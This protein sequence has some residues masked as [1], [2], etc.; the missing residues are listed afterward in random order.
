MMDPTFRVRLPISVSLILIS[1]AQR[2]QQGDFASCQGDS[3]Y[4]PSSHH[5]LADYKDIWRVFSL[6]L[7]LVLS[8]I[9]MSLQHPL[10]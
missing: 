3:Q 7:I 9:Y 5:C 8:F 1:P 6:V 2:L 10:V 4:E